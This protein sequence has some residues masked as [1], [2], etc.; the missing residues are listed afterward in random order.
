MVVIY[1]S[2]DQSISV[3]DK[4]DIHAAYITSIIWEN[5]N[6]R[7]FL[8]SSV[9]QTISKCKLNSHEKIELL[10]KFRYDESVLC[11]KNFHSLVLAGMTNNIVAVIEP[12]RG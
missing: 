10:K 5:E 4:E 12:E 8:T 11:L 1:N 9:D 3:T 6:K 7:V 2:I